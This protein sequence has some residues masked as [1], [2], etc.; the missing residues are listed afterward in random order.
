VGEK[1]FFKLLDAEGAVRLRMR[2]GTTAGKVADVFVQLEVLVAGEWYVVVRYDT[3]HGFP[4]RDV[5]DA[6]GRVTKTAHDLP[7]L[8][9]F[10]AFAEQDLKDRWE[11]YRDRWMRGRRRRGGR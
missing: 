2:V 4:H 11:W 10:L 6:A 7:D 8:G 3:A 1:E 9:S 5:V